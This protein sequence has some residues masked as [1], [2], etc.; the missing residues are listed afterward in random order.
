MY[1]QPLVVTEVAAV[2]AGRDVSRRARQLPGQ[3]G[4]CE[5]AESFGP[6]AELVK[7]ARWRDVLRASV[8]AT[9]ARYGG[10]P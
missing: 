6:L 3:P 10:A 1:A 4:P 5:D 7:P 2:G 8:A 9:L